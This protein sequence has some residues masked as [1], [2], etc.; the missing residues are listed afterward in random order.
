M[1]LSLT[2]QFLCGIFMFKEGR[3]LRIWCEMRSWSKVG[4]E[5]QMVYYLI[6][7]AHIQFLIIFWMI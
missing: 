1:T 5:A 4:H 2:E 3:G 6:L 7:T